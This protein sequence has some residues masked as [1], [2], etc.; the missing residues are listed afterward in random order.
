MVGAGTGALLSQ[1]PAVKSIF[2]LCCVVLFVLCPVRQ[3]GDMRVF[4]DSTF[5][6]IKKYNISQYLHKINI[7]YS[8]YI[9]YSLLDKQ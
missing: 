9:I 4:D 3:G 6:F 2:S 1:L 5:I 7:L 8:K